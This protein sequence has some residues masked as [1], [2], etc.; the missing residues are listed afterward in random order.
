MRNMFIRV[1]T[2]VLVLGASASLVMASEN[3]ASPVELA[4]QAEYL[5]STN[6]SEAARHEAEEALRKT[7]STVGLADINVADLYYLVA[8][9]ALVSGDYDSAADFA[10]MALAM[11]EDIL[12]PEHSTLAEP[13]GL[14]AKIYERLNLDEK[15]RILHRS[16]LEIRARMCEGPADPSVVAQARF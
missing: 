15:A 14:L 13:L 2:A 7:I 11:R 6:Q 4:L 16:E 3:S 10:R 5:L 12:G 8:R 1:W 9:I